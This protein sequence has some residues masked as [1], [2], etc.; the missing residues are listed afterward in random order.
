MHDAVNQ[1][2][3]YDIVILDMGMPGMNGLQLAQAISAD[4]ALHQT[5]MLILSSAVHV[6]R[7]ALIAAGVSHWLTKPVA[8]AALNSQLK[9][10]MVETPCPVS[11]STQHRWP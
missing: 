7:P 8:S 5:R 1:G 9:L 10:M 6:D 11:P 4:Q 3:P 2:R